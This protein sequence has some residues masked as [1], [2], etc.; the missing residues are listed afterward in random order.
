MDYYTVCRAKK[1]P[2]TNPQGPDLANGFGNALTAALDVM[3]FTHEVDINA[4]GLNLAKPPTTNSNQIPNP[5]NTAPQVISG[6]LTTS[7]DV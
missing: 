3:S 1:D 6:N 5:P 2:L 7:G 4:Q